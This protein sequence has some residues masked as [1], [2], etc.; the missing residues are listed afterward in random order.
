MKER[1]IGRTLFKIFLTLNFLIELVIGLGMLFN[2]P[3]LAEPGFGIPYSSDMDVLAIGL[4]SN[5]L[6]A[7][8]AI[9]L[10]LVWTIRNKTEGAS[11]G[12]L[13]GGL[14]VFFSLMAYAQMGSTQALLVDGVR[15]LLTI[16]FGLMAYNE[17]KSLR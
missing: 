11:L 10:S 6:F 5:L 15:G 7:A 2:F 4:G 16:I 14:F 12:M 9:L 3:V 1:K 13:T 17:L 8:A